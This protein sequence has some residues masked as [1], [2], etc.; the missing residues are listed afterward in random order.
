MGL[1]ANQHNGGYGFGSTLTYQG[2]LVE[3]GQIVAEDLH[4]CGD[5]HGDIECCLPFVLTRTFTATDCAGNTST[6]SYAIVSDGGA[7]PDGAGTTAERTV[8]ADPLRGGGSA[9]DSGLPDIDG[10]LR[11]APNPATNAVRVDLQPTGNTRLAID[12]LDLSGSV[13]SSVMVGRAEAGV[14]VRQ[15]FDVS[16]IPP[17]F[18]QLRVEEGTRQRFVPLV[19]R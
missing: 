6:F 2:T 18:Y 1:G 8:A 14:P 4:C 9:T 15:A 3:Q 11:V 10:T 16:S 13:I 7:C 12:L 19:V 5:L 17:G